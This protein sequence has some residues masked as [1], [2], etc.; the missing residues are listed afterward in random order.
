MINTHMHTSRQYTY[1]NTYYYLLVVTT[2]VVNEIR[3]QRVWYVKKIFKL[4]TT[5]L[6]SMRNMRRNI[7]N[8]RCCCY[9]TV[10]G[11]QKRVEEDESS[12]VTASFNCCAKPECNGGI[13]VVTL[14]YCI[15]SHFRGHPEQ[16]LQNPRLRNYIYIC[17]RSYL[18]KENSGHLRHRRTPRKKKNKNEKKSCTSEI[19]T[20]LRNV[21]LVKR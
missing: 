3:E 9:R 15:F 13:L 4:P 12:R 21:L 7:Y 11:G 16:A 2:C 19:R 20:Y 6:V 14:V 10:L 17:T 18:F 8:W 1:V 5:Y